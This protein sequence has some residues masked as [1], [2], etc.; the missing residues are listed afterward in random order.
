MLHGCHMNHSVTDLFKNCSQYIPTKTKCQH[1]FLLNLKSGDFLI[2]QSSVSK[3]YFDYFQPQ[4][5]LKMIFP[6]FLL[7]SI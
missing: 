4:L 6:L 1:F 7:L 5:M 2:A 3:A